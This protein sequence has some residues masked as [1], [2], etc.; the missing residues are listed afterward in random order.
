MAL[1]DQPQGQAHD[2]HVVRLDKDVEPIVTR[3]LGRK[4]GDIQQ[5]RAALGDQDFETV[6][7]LGHDLKGAGE[8]FGFP[9]LSAVGA[10]LERSAKAGDVATIREQV[11]AL[12]HYLASLEVHFS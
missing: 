5:L 10:Q 2:R 12:E 6:R 3:F 4:R 8:G 7:R 11:D 1:T 9:R